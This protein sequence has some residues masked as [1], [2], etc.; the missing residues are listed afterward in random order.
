VG[1]DDDETT[2]CNSRES[3]FGKKYEARVCF[4]FDCYMKRSHIK[5]VVV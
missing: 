5:E 2:R 1:E 4:E 3:V